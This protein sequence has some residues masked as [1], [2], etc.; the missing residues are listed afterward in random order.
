MEREFGQTACQTKENFLR[1]YLQNNYSKL[2]SLKFLIDEVRE[3]NMINVLSLG[4]G[5]CILEWLLKLCVFEKTKIV[6]SEF[7]P[8]LVQKAKEFLP[9]ITALQFDFFNDDIYSFCSKLNIEFDLAVF[10]GSAYVM[11]DPEFIKL[12]S[13]I[14]R[15]GV[16][17]IIDFHAGYMNLRSCVSYVLGPI[18]KISA[19]RKLFRK[20]PVSDYKGKFHGYSRSRSELRKLYKESGWRLRKETS[21]GIY[22]YVAILD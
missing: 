2:D 7:D 3:S 14:K 15:C 21:S 11:D 12:F 9:E 6:A 4:A 8:F 17:K 13:A 19:V 22:E 5:A 18:T 1:W 16:R 20:P 10:F